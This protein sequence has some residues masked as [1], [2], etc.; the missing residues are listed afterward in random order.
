MVLGPWLSQIFTDLLRAIY[1]FEIEAMPTRNILVVDDE[2][3]VRKAI[4]KI[5]QLDGYDVTAVGDAASALERA[6]QER[7]DLVLTDMKMPEMDGLELMQALSKIHP[8]VI[9]IVMTGYGSSE[10]AKIAIRGGAYDYILKPVSA[11]DIRLAVENAFEREKLKE[12]VRKQTEALRKANRELKEANENLRRLDKEKTKFLN[13]VAHDLRT[14][15]ASIRTYADMILMYRDEPSEV[16]EEFLNIIIQE[17][18][19]LGNLISNLLNL[20]RIESGT[21]Q[22]ERKP[23]DLRE[24]INHFISV[25]RGQADPLDISL[26]AGIPEDLPEIVGDRNGLG[27]VIANLFSN[28]VKYTPPGG[29]IRVDVKLDPGSSILDAG[30]WI[31]QARRPAPTSSI[32]YQEIYVSVSD[33]GIGIPEQYHDKIF[34]RFGRVETEEG[35]V[36]EGIGLGLA[37]AKQIVEHHG[38]RIWVESEEGKGSCLTFT[39]PVDS[40]KQE[41]VILEGEANVS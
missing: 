28:A 34:E 1:I 21:A 25:Y 24:L 10:T 22:Y 9:T 35:A 18:D 33:T 23:V 5:L 13:T 19:R 20:A 8:E 14:P 37:I 40:G 4:H 31:G 3:Q 11:A 41:H 30:F 36:K 32:E 27:Q 6:K 26:T 2:E 12:E 7:F 29:E 17:S 39:L 15:L 38:G 16:H